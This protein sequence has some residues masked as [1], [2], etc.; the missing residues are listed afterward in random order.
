MKFNFKKLTLAHYFL[1]FLIL[2]LIGVFWAANFG[3]PWWIWLIIFLI[4]IANFFFFRAELKALIIVVVIIGFSG[5]VFWQHFVTNKVESRLEGYNQ[6]EISGIGKVYNSSSF[7]NQGLFYISIGKIDKTE[8]NAKIFAVSYQSRAVFDINSNASFKGKLEKIQKPDYLYNRSQKEGIY[9]KIAKAEI[10]PSNQKI[11][12]SSKIKNF[13]QSVSSG[14]V[15]FKNQV[16]LKIAQTLPEPEASFLD[17]ILLGSRQ[18][19]DQQTLNE[20]SATGTSH[21]IALSGFNI[22]IIIYFLMIVFKKLSPKVS[23]IIILLAIVSFVVMT[24]ASASIVRAA[25]MGTV[26]LLAKR[27]GRLSEASISLC[28]AAFLI[29]LFNPNVIRYD[30]GFQ[31]S[32]LATI[33]IVYLQPI[34]ENKIEKRFPSAPKLLNQTFSATISAQVMVLPVLILSFGKMSIVSPIVNLIVVPVIPLAMLIGFIQIIF[35]FI[36]I[37]LGLVIG[38]V[39]WLILKFCLIII[40]FFSRLPFSQVEIT[41]FSNLILIAYYIIIGILVWYLYKRLKIKKQKII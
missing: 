14:L 9:Y 5:G 28:L 38:W 11:T 23:F 8:V 20:L 16:S 2:F 32:F 30:I 18:N 1:I 25:I 13:F 17:G 31:L 22:T 26:M 29:V 4:S 15:S 35:S 10:A 12:S 40:S 27:L 41:K 37:K 24:G 7:G 19:L 6:K 39:S 36:W 3:L 33:G 34:L 21:L